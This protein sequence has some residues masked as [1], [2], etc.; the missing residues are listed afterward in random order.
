MMS[1]IITFYGGILLMAYLLLGSYYIGKYE[2]FINKS[3]YKRFY[4]LL[5]WIFYIA[6]IAGIDDKRGVRK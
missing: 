2:E 1:I 5:I 3:A 4:I 6:Y